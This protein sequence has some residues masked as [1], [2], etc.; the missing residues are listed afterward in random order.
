TAFQS[1]IANLESGQ[2]GFLLTGQ[3]AYL[4]PYERATR[5]W[6]AEIDRLRA[7]VADS[8]E[9]DRPERT[10][11]LDDLESLTATAVERLERTIARNGRAPPSGQTDL[12][13]TDWATAGTDRVRLL[14]DRLMKQEDTRIEA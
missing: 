3:T 2:R 8:G 5:T 10:Q 6:R 1:T 9:F 14:I 4:E 13:A 7:L 12:A 11:D